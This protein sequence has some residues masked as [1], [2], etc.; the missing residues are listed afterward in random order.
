MKKTLILFIILITAQS[1]I[2][3]RIAPNIDDYK[4]T[5]GKKFKK[6]LP[7]REMF[8]FEDPKESDHFYNYVDTKFQLNDENV[9]DD[10]PFILN[11]TQYFFSFYEVEIPTKVVNLG[12]MFADAMLDD[13]GIGPLFEDSY[14]NRKGHWYIAIEV[15]S[16]L[17][18]DCLQ[19][20]AL[21]REA[22]LKYLRTLKQE[23]LITH[24][25]NETV[26]KN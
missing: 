15:Y 6:S 26:F 9:Y 12:V 8:V 19:F 2:P 5:R 23:Y 18:K 14:G 4:V 1:C 7:K 20:N 25:Y 10:V 13:A 16:D 17:E 22:V 21:S 3:I 24:N 11:N